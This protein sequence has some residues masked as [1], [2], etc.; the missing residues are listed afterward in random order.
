MSTKREQQVT[1]YEV[2]VV[3]RLV[4]N[5]LSVCFYCIQAGQE[6]LEVPYFLVL[7]M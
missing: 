6:R 5:L 1:G 4:G 3:S 2:T 7:S